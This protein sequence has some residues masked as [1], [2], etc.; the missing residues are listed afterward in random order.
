MKSKNKRD[1]RKVKVFLGY[2][3]YN[4]SLKIRVIIYEFMTLRKFNFGNGGT[5]N[6]FIDDMNNPNTIFQW[7]L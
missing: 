1:K 4:M 2:G 6:K 3:T 7:I 5:Q